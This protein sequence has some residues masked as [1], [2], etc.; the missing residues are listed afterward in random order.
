MKALLCQGEAIG[1]YPSREVLL[2]YWDE[3][4]KTVPE[5]DQVDVIGNFDVRRADE[6]VADYDVVLGAWISD[7]VFTRA[8]FERHPNL[9]YVSTF[10][11]GFGKIDEVAAF[12]KG[13]IFTNTVYGD[14]TIAQFGMA[15]LLDI[16]HDIR[17]QSI[18]YKKALEENKSLRESGGAVVSRQ[19]ELYEKTIGIIGLGSIGLWMAKMAAG[20][21]MHV[22]AY[23][24]TR[25]KG[26]AYEFI[27]QVS[28]DELY[29][30]SDVISIHCPLTDE[31]KGM[32]DRAAFEKMKD[33][34]I[35]INTARGAIID[36]EAFVDA[37]NSGKVYAA[38][39]DVVDGEPLSKKT[40]IFDC[41]NAII[42]PHIAWAPEEAR[43]RTVRI[44]VDNLKNWLAGT[45]TSVIY[46]TPTGSSSEALQKWK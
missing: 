23:S 45:P 39:L 21:G 24:R 29:A 35:V 31:T 16:C 38:G 9:K 20:F 5:L 6:L 36:E 28:L 37:L 13:I 17:L 22:V 8:F 46:K 26:A 19:V 11:H 41:P 15:L 42:T 27:E 30:R 25:K 7:G 3:L 1:G 32:V 10:G 33:G 43:Y 12:E 2:K 4:L 34:V 18:H 14:M 44:A 40:P